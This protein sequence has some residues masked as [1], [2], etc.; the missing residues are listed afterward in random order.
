MPTPRENTS[1]VK[2]PVL[3]R[4]PHL[5]RTAAAKATLAG[6]FGYDRD[7]A[8]TGQPNAGP[9]IATAPRDATFVEPSLASKANTEA[10]KQ[11]K[12][13]VTPAQP[14]E[15]QAATAESFMRRWGLEIKRSVILLAA[16]ALLWGAWA[17]G[18]KSVTAPNESN[19]AEIENAQTATDSASIAAAQTTNDHASDETTD[20][21]RVAHIV[22]PTPRSSTGSSGGF[23]PVAEPE[24]SFYG[25][26]DVV[27]AVASPMPTAKNDIE[28]DFSQFSPDALQPPSNGD[29]YGDYD[30]GEPANA[31]AQ[32]P[33][34]MSEAA[35]SNQTALNQ[36][37]AE[38]AIETTLPA[39]TNFVPSATP[40]KPGF[41]PN[42]IGSVED[43]KPR[44]RPALSSTPNAILDWSRYLPD[45][46]GTA[47]IRAVSATQAIGE[48]AD[49]TKPADSQAIYLEKNEP[50]A[51][52][53]GVAPFYR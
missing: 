34:M 15:W 32:K 44:N 31:S 3:F 50:S 23:A 48:A 16:I 21:P 11:T 28:A 22:E 5:Q 53:V 41:D 39:A 33:P 47:A 24:Q 13:A 4:L 51:S 46:A 8:A 38:P 49:P 14:I 29:F 18:Q 40:E 45:A 42:K 37:T 27:P 17:M 19:L 52:N 43:A 20:H 36:P 26:E 12:S 9:T 10:T 7:G 35:E 1:I 2:A 25:S 6:G 30:I